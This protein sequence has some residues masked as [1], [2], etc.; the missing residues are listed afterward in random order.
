MIGLEHKS[1]HIIW[2][3]QSCFNLL[4][5]QNKGEQ[6]SITI[7]PFDA[8]TQSKI[9]R[10]KSDIILASQ[11][12]K[13]NDLLTGSETEESV[14]IIDQPGEYELKDIFIKGIECALSAKN[15]D[16][17]PNI[18][19]VIEAEGIK[20]CHLGMLNTK[21][22]SSDQIEE[23]GSVDVL[24]VPVGDQVVL[25]GGEAASIVNEI[26]PKIVIPMY[27]RLPDFKTKLDGVD[28]FLKAMGEKSPEVLEKLL[29][30]QKDLPEETT[31]VVVLKP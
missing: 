6:V 3:G 4:V 20:V 14:F 24:L 7:D 25:E 27:Y 16:A 26:E 2:K 1:M 17:Q 21:E 23:I 28:V 12:V 10:S 18:I 19:Y 8:Q 13:R 29:I 30:K 31:K 11:K 9:S 22:L 15:K 5:S